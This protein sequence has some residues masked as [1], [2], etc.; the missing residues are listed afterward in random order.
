MD[1]RLWG[2]I[3]VWRLTTGKNT[4]SAHLLISDDC[5]QVFHNVAVFGIPF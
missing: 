3:V 1:V 4:K 5:A 2:N